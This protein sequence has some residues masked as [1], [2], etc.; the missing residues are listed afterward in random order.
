MDNCNNKITLLEIPSETRYWFV[1]AGKEARYYQDFLQSEYIGLDDNGVTLSYLRKLSKEIK[2][3]DELLE[4]YKQAFEDHDLNVFKNQAE[5]IPRT[6]EEYKE[7]LAS[8]KRK[9]K[10]RAKRIYNFV[11]SMSEGDVVIVPF[12]SSNKFLIG[13]I[14]SDCLEVKISKTLTLS[15]K[16]YEESNYGLRRNVSWIKELSHFEFPDKLYRASSAHQSLLELTTY[17]EDI[18]GLL[19]PYH[20]Y[21]GQCYYRMSVNTK[22]AI[23]SLT[24][25]EY[26]NLLRDIV[27]DDLDQVYQKNKVQSPGEIVLYVKENWWLIPIIWAVLF[28]DIQIPTPYVKIKV[29][30]IVKYFSK[31][32]VEKRRLEVEEKRVNIE[33]Q[34]ASIRQKDAE[35][36]SKI[37]P[38]R[39]DVQDLKEDANKA[40]INDIILSMQNSD[41]SLHT[42]NISINSNI[43]QEK[44]MRVKDKLDLSD[45]DVGT[46]ISS[47]KIENR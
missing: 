30:G 41:G 34:K 5:T 42:K 3:P 44:V 26:Q 38:I 28:G 7:S 36:L 11:E 39:Q 37:T 21:K 40:I 10:I 16:G 47:S 33:N 17:A 2:V 20:L 13:V 23:S 8:E 9:S 22:E 35:T 19:A 6:E 4:A 43:D 15:D 14:T 12:V 24:W 1:R 45:E 29:Q 32:E 18:N 31:N 27:G 25:L 46:A